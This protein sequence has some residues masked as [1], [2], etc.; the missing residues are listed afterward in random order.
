MG[1][2]SKCIVASGAAILGMLVACGANDEVGSDRDARSVDPVTLGVVAEAVSV[3]EILARANEYLAAN[4][5]YCGGINGGTDYICGGTCRRPKAAWDK[6][7]SDCSGFVSWCWQIASCPTT[8]GFMRDVSGSNGWRTVKIDE[9]VAGDAV[10]CDGHIKLFSKFVGEG[11]AEVYEEY[12]CGHTARKSVQAFTR[13]GNTLRFAYDSRVY[14]GI[15]RNSLVAPTEPVSVQ[16]SLDVAGSSIDGWVVDMGAKE[17]SLV[18]DAWVDGDAQSGF[19][20]QG[21]AD[22]A[23]PDVAARLGVTPNHGFSIPTPLYFCDG[24]EH[25]LT[26]VAG[27]TPITGA[28][29][30][31]S[32]AVPPAI[33]GVLREVVDAAALGAWKLDLHT[34]LRWVTPEDHAAYK[35]AAPLPA[36]PHAGKS[37]DGRAWLVDGRA[38]RLLADAGVIAAWGL[39]VDELSPLDAASARLPEGPEMPS[40]PVLVKA[41]GG[42]SVFVLDF[43]PAHPADDPGAD[44]PVYLGQSGHRRRIGEESASCA[45]VPAPARPAPG[46][47]LV[48]VGVG[49]LASRR[50]RRRP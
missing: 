48:G 15:R 10:V 36:A 19:H 25:A 49:L 21:R 12:N 13:S 50:R 14:H 33:Q 32:C 37:S 5:P 42:S 23:R 24:R 31:L 29:K 7:R 4:V 17:R 46:L 9:L 39:D 6:Y 34:S 35:N 16:S 26:V 45:S 38:R 41:V 44:E 28:P 2:L 22:V 27:K 40:K 3:D 30:K 20:V 18:V 11:K 8:D 43:D 47:L 1:S